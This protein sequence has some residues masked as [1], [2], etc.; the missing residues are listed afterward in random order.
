MGDDRVSCSA[1][2]WSRL[3]RGLAGEDPVGRLEEALYEVVSTLLSHI[4]V[5][6]SKNLCLRSD[7]SYSNPRTM[8][9]VRNGLAPLI[10]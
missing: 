1:R 3:W 10:P 6:K 4:A 5:M 9:Q 2:L 8:W 7:L